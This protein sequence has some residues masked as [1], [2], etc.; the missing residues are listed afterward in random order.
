MIPLNEASNNLWGTSSLPW[1]FARTAG[2]SSEAAIIM[3]RLANLAIAEDFL[4]EQRINAVINAV[5]CFCPSLSRLP[6]S[7]ACSNYSKRNKVINEY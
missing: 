1:S 5:T 7:V 3:A 6:Y 4:G 2:S